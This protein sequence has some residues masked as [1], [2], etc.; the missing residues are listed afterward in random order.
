MHTLKIRWTSYDRHGVLA[1]EA[2]LFIPADGGVTVHG[3]LKI[4]DGDEPMEHWLEGSYFEYRSVFEQVEFDAES[5]DIVYSEDTG[6]ECIETRISDG[7]LIKVTHG[8]V[9]TW[10]TASN[11][12]ILG[13]TGA[14][15][16]R[17]AP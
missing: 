8:G 5:G 3:E 15:I 16:E 6:A 9:E 4:I 7:R 10:Y 12:W 13:P 14:T 2:T 17:V 11:A 1:D